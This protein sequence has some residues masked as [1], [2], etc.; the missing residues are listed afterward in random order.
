MSSQF[1]K[2][3][4]DDHVLL[5]RAIICAF[6][7][8]VGIQSLSFA[9]PPQGTARTIVSDDFTKNRKE[10]APTTANT[11]GTQGPASNRVPTKPRRP[12]RTYRLAASTLTRPIA[13]GAIVAQLGITIWR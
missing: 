13:P 7:V 9:N 3:K 4:P 10:A 11:K 1:T 6:L 8:L 2:R 5:P 12:R